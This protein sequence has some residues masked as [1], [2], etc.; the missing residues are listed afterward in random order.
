MRDRIV[1]EEEKK[2]QIAGNKLLLHPG[3][4]CGLRAYLKH[5]SAAEPH[6]KLQGKVLLSKILF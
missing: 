6:N 2:Q 3:S 4:F 1:E 5:L